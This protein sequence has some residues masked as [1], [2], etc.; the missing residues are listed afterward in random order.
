[1]NAVRDETA[2]LAIELR[3]DRKVSHLGLGDYCTFISCI[4]SVG[5]PIS[6]S[7]GTRLVLKS[8]KPKEATKYV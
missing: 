1:M 4:R 2:R 6:P 5:L 7:R 3:S 8:R